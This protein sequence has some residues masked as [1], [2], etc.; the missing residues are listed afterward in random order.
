MIREEDEMGKNDSGRERKYHS[1][2]FLYLISVLEGRNLTVLRQIHFVKIRLESML[3]NSV[4]TSTS[5]P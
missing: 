3:M 4:K 2:H 1:E 5:R